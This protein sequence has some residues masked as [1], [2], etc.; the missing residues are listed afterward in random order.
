MSLVKIWI[1]AVWSTKHR[2]PY[3][4]DKKLKNETFQFIKKYCEEKDIILDCIGGFTEHLHC[5]IRLKAT[6]NIAET[7]KL[8]KGASSFWINKNELTESPFSWQ[9]EYYAASFS[10]KDLNAVRRYI[11]NQEQIHQKR[12]FEDELKMMEQKWF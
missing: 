7:I 4:E 9:Q 10:L 11:Q 2:F 6:Q 5:C 1:H 12:N 8:I 3:F